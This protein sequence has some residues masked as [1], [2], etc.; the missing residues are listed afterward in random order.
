ML[1]TVYMYTKHLE[2]AMYKEW[3]LSRQHQYQRLLGLMMCGGVSFLSKNMNRNVS[4]CVQIVMFSDSYNP[5]LVSIECTTV[6]L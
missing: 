4:T 6:Q 5:I 1:L 2:W 3:H